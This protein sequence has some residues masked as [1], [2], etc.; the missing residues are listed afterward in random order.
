M[1]KTGTQSGDGRELQIKANC[2]SYELYK[3]NKGTQV[4]AEPFTL[5]DPTVK[6]IDTDFDVSHSLAARKLRYYHCHHIQKRKAPCGEKMNRIQSLY[7]NTQ[8]ILTGPTLLRTRRST[9]SIRPRLIPAYS[10][11]TL[12]RTSHVPMASLN[13]KSSISILLCRVR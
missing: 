5:A 12:V 8:Q 6:S 4:I 13:Y 2:T 10:M 3:I 11:N 9:S 7:L 1:F